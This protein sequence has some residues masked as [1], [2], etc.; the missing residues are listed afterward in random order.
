MC[1][2][3]DKTRLRAPNLHAWMINSRADD[4]AQAHRHYNDKFGVGVFYAYV[5]IICIINIVSFSNDIMPH[6]WLH[7]YLHN[8]FG[9]EAPKRG[10]KMALEEYIILHL[11]LLQ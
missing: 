6:R 10:L 2:C 5:L 7:P 4:P 11:V 8:K 1:L 3:V 9:T